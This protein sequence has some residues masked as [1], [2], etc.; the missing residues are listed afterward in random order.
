M[1]YMAA[2][3]AGPFVFPVSKRTMALGSLEIIIRSELNSNQY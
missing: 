3:Y 1:G 2:H